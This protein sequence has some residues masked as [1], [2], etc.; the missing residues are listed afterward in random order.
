MTK[1]GKEVLGMM[2]RENDNRVG[3]GAGDG[4]GKEKELLTTGSGTIIGMVHCLPLPGTAGFGGDYEKILSR[5]VEDAVTLERAGVDAVIVENM[6][7]VPFGALLGTA[8]LAALSAA[9]MEVR[10][11]VKIPIGIDA[12]F[13]DCKS[14]LA[15]AGITGADFIRVPVFVDTVLF[16]DGYIMPCAKEC[17]VY[18]RQLGLEHVKIL[19][20]VQVKHAHM[21]LP[22]ITVEQSAREAGA[23]G[24]DA[25]IVTGSEIGVETPIEMIERVKKAISLP[26]LAG[27]GVNASNIR[28]QMETA[29]GAIIG[30]SLKKGGILTNPI[31]YGLVCEVMEG[32]SKGGTKK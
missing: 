12:A 32:L 7:D 23:N 20:D 25:V 14:S 15:I 27:S 13:N 28:G 6:G 22:Q 30:S 4:D 8:Q 17:M 10:R 3:N 29:D 24:A 9:A 5:A 2:E 16:T 1:R 11:A 31:D 26:V 21:L 18:R 19:A